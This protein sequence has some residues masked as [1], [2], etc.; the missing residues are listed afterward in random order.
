MGVPGFFAWI[1]KNWK[2]K[3]IIV[4]SI[5]IE[6]DTLYI[7]AN[8]LFHPCCFK[9]LNYYQKTIDPEKLERK[10]FR[11]ITNYIDYLIGY[12]QPKN[13][14]YISVD[15]VAPMAKINQQRNRRFKSIYDE[16]IR[17][18]IKI[19]HDKST[20]NEWSNTVI[21]PGTEFMERL[22]L[23]L[24]TYINSKK[25][26]K[27]KI[28]YSSYHTP[29]EGEHKILQDIRNRTD[30]S[31]TGYVIYGLDADLIFLALA[32][33][34]KNIFLLRE[35][36]EF[37]KKEKKDDI[38]YSI[39]DDVAET[40]NFVKIDVLKEVINEEM[41]A[42]INKK[43]GNTSLNLNLTNDFVFICYLLGN[44]FLP[45]LPSIDIKTN[46]IELLLD[47]YT[48]TYIETEN[49]LINLE[50]SNNVYIN[51]LFLNSMLE[52]VQRKE[53]YYFKEIFPRYKAFV[54]KRK[55]HLN[56]PYEIEMWKL[57][58]MVLFEVEDPVQLG[59]GDPDV[60]KFRYYEYHFHTSEHQIEL[61]KSACQE[62][63]KGLV[64]VTRYYF[65]KCCSWEWQYPYLHAPFLS[66]ISYHLTGFKNMNNVQFEDSK[67]LSPCVQLLIVLPP[68]CN[69]I[70][71][72]SYQ[73][74][75]VSSKSPVIDMYPKKITLDMIN[76]DSYYKCESK[77]P[78]I[79]I[80]RIHQTIKHLQL[81]Y[82]EEIRNKTLDVF[83]NKR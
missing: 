5:N 24:V 14:V 67:P 33:Q 35:E 75:T 72:K 6:I 16:T 2:K 82:E 69:K 43:K 62:Y 46:G 74:L 54:A 52:K 23:E 45:H 64:W 40:F 31:D 78:I 47:C 22:H 80:S 4:P 68:A 1:I 38:I 9:V 20:F 25:N 83:V 34:R 11:R 70:L 7:D 37:G 49:L 53:D 12:V 8:C 73:Y 17:K 30:N 41:T 32:S 39:T 57:D 13:K 66:D 77:I 29:G 63:I 55:C 51:D 26:V 19:K 50:Q 81:S 76:K 10:M 36:V 58:N 79:N 27:V 44:D 56:D 42:L 21:T 48:D 18:N 61:V 60:Y 65:D 3:E 59:D 71:P 28:E 15:G